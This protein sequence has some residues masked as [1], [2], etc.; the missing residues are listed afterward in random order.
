MIDL[1]SASSVLVASSSL[2]SPLSRPSA[3]GTQRNRIQQSAA[4][5]P[6][7]CAVNMLGKP[8]AP[9]ISARRICPW[10]HQGAARDIAR[11]VIYLARDAPWNTGAVMAVDGGTTAM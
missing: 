1:A 6:A 5:I 4:L 10:P 2:H 7:D 8:I 3:I 9:E 11:A